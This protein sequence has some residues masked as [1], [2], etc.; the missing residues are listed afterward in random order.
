ML[1]RAAFR[2]GSLLL[3]LLAG[4]SGAVWASTIELGTPELIEAFEDSL[5]VLVYPL[6]TG[7]ANE[8][9]RLIAGRA[10]LEITRTPEALPQ[11]YSAA[12]CCILDSVDWEQTLL[13]A[14]AAERVIG[15][16]ASY[17]QVTGNLVEYAGA[18]GEGAEM[19]VLLWAPAIQGAEAPETT[20]AGVR[21]LHDD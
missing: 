1:T 3:L 16:G 6:P 11:V 18:C 17:F 14:I 13:S 5:H 15:P 7:L 19:V 10:R 4:T 20:I 9:G 21:L 12:I 8:A 2:I